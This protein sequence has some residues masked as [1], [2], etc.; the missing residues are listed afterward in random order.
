MNTLDYW[1]TW[2]GEV[3]HVKGLRKGCVF[4]LKGFQGEIAILETP[5]TH[6]KYNSHYKNLYHVNRNIN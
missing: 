1:R 5:K 4:I 2:I 6:R 3:V